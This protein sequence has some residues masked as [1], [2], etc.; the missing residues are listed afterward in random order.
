LRSSEADCSHFAAVSQTAV[1]PF[2]QQVQPQVKVLHNG[3]ETDRCR[4]ETSRPEF[5]RR[6]NI[7][8]TA[9][10]IGYVGRYSYEKF[11]L[12]AALAV[13]HIDRPDVVALFCG[14]GWRKA[15]VVSD[16]KSL[17]GDRA[18]FL[19]Y[20]ENV[21]DVLNGI[22]VCMAASPAE[23]FSL[24]ITEAWY[25]EV[26]CVSTRV[27]SVPELEKRFGQLAASVPVHASPSELVAGTQEALSS[28]FLEDC[29]P[30]AKAMVCEHFTAEKMAERWEDYLISIVRPAETTTSNT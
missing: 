13:R 29:V 15:D 10:V 22:D 8:E 17:I 23:G 16:V 28:R 9:T 19:P 2:S 20:Q 4:V 6:W 7:P 27:G 21:G 12:A 25:C 24:A 18:I 30:R 11:P 5:R 1:S 26:P 3:I 14:E